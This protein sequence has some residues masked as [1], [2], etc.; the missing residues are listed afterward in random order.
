[1]RTATVSNLDVMII[2]FFILSSIG[3]IWSFLDLR[4]RRKKTKH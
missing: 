3:V 1:M 2:V 4:R